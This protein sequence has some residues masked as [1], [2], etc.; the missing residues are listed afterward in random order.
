MLRSDA[1]WSFNGV[2]CTQFATNP[3]VENCKQL[4]AIGQDQNGD[5]VT[6]SVACAVTCGNDGTA[7]DCVA[8][9]EPEPEPEPELDTE[10]DSS[11]SN[12][13]SSALLEEVD[14]GSWDGIG[15]EYSSSWDGDGATSEPSVEP[16]GNASL[17]SNETGEVLEP[18]S[19][20]S[21]EPAGNASLGSNETGEVL[22][23]ASEPSVEPVLLVR[24]AWEA[25]PFGVCP[26]DDCGLGAVLSRTV[27]CTVITVY[28]SGE[29]V[30]AT[31]QLDEGSTTR[32]IRDRPASTKECPTLGVGASCNDGNPKTM[33]DVCKSEQADSCAG[34]VQ[35]AAS[36][37]LPINTALIKVDVLAELQAEDITTETLNAMPLSAPIK[38]SLATAFNVS[39]DDIILTKIEVTS[40]RRRRLQSAGLSIEYVIA[41][42]VAEA[43][44]AQDFSTDDSFS[45]PDVT[46]PAEATADGISIVI[47]SADILLEPLRSYA[48]VKSTACSSE[49]VCSNRC[50]TE[51]VV[52]AD[53]Y[54]CEED[55][56]DVNMS[57]C[58]ALFGVAPS[59]QAV[60][61]PAAEAE[62]CEQIEGLIVNTV[63]PADGEPPPPQSSGPSG[64][65]ILVA[66]GLAL[67]VLSTWWYHTRT[68]GGEEAKAT[69]G[70]ASKAPYMTKH[71][72]LA[73]VGRPLVAEATRNAPTDL[74]REVEAP[75][76]RALALPPLTAKDVALHGKMLQR[77]R[78]RPRPVSPPPPSLH[79][80]ATTARAAA[81]LNRRRRCS[82]RPVSPPG[83]ASPRPISPPRPVSP[84]GGYV[85]MAPSA[86]RGATSPR[87]V[88]P[89][90]G[91]PVQMVTTSTSAERGTSPQRAREP[92]PR[93]VSPTHPPPAAS[94]ESS[95]V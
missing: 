50:G 85:H 41:L 55:G 24:Y 40:R 18:A 42:P 38:T 84:P 49:H 9:R 92:K 93:P 31:E 83:L 64:V 25:F 74:K 73:G 2:S 10:T 69:A 56:T 57:I 88:S 95:W 66:L 22:E 72:L 20:P 47:E 30:R 1:V 46:V 52:A 7:R 75:S 33:N 61:C 37:R 44:A 28:N 39:V 15:V 60:C 68:S 27:T 81:A 6:A 71:Q 90:A 65:Y 82:P 89:Q 94:V 8:P 4:W 63:W 79:S 36:V 43:H 91:S 53:V 86:L 17:G 23:P 78:R 29:V 5:T 48:Y 87:P 21:V 19:E 58:E 11:S 70:T 77:G 59:T 35:L 32:C 34:R 45:I 3:G 12:S 54:R 80:L 67:L 51:T 26:A 13:W 62:T 16:S 14:S 76:V